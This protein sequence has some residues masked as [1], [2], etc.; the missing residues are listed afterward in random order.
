[1]DMGMDSGG[2]VASKKRRGRPKKLQTPAEVEAETAA[3]IIMR[4]ITDI[5]ITL[6]QG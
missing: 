4:T 6:Q 5:I 2:E 1:M 3:L